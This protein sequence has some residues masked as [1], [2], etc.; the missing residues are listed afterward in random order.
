MGV[1]PNTPLHLV[2]LPGLLEMASEATFAAFR[3]DLIEAGYGDIR[4]THGCVFRFVHEDGMRLTELAS[5]AGM[6]KQSIGEIVDDLASRGYVERFPDP[7]DRRAKLIR[8]TKKGEKAQAIG[9]DLFASLEKRL[10]KRYGRDRVA[11]LRALL[12][13]VVT[14]EAPEYAPEL[15]QRERGELASAA[16]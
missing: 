1:P 8:L 13:E 6:T 9:L 4:P 14:T 10:A 11:D 3:E 2:P 15:S 16:S 7:A 5:L 12:E